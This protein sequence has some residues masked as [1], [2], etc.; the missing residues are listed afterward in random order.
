MDVPVTLG[1]TLHGQINSLI[2]YVADSS[3]LICQNSYEI[4]FSLVTVIE[5]VY[6]DGQLKIVIPGHI[7][8]Q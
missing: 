8:N 2:V 6:D 3:E 7:L 5:R 4:M 1:R